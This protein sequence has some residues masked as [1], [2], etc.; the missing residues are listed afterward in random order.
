LLAFLPPH[1]LLKLMVSKRVQISALVGNHILA[2]CW[3]LVRRRAM[4]YSS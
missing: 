2:C 1:L 4:I 3:T